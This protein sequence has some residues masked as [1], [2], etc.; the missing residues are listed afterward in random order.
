ML[1]EKL[2]CND[3]IDQKRSLYLCK[4]YEAWCSTDLD[5]PR[6]DNVLDPRVAHAEEDCLF[7]VDSVLRFLRGSVETSTSK[8]GRFSFPSTRCFAGKRTRLW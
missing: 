2:T 7:V 4:V 1:F 5:Q 3:G 6:V 8:D